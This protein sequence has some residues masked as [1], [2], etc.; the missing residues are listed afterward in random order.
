MCLALFERSLI[1]H[2]KVVQKI[3]KQN[4]LNNGD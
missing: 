1:N 4:H 3:E 2:G